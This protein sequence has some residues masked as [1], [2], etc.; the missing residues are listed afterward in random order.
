MCPKQNSFVVL[1]LV[2]VIGRKMFDGISI[3]NSAAPISVWTLQH[4]F[5]AVNFACFFHREESMVEKLKKV[6]NFCST[7]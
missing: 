2:S 4:I 5:L 7:S 3:K 6:N 1:N